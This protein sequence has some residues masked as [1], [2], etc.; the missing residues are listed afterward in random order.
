MIIITITHVL[1]PPPFSFF[2]IL[3]WGDGADNHRRR[4]ELPNSKLV[5]LFF[6]RFMRRGI[7]ICR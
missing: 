4:D 7:P 3:S 2:L 5:S 6:L 1:S